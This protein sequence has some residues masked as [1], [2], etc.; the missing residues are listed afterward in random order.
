MGLKSH[1]VFV[2]ACL[3]AM[4]RIAPEQLLYDLGASLGCKR[5]SE[6]LFSKGLRDTFSKH[7]LHTFS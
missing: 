3:V 5:S 4:F 1:L 7:L 2:V 6:D